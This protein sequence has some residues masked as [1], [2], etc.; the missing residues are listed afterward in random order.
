MQKETTLPYIH[1]YYIIDKPY[2]RLER[3]L[4]KLLPIHLSDVRS[5]D[6]FI[7]CHAAL[8][9]MSVTLKFLGEFNIRVTGNTATRFWI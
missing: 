7:E 3:I 9:Y 5:G 6:M 1:T 2:P 8:L 4:A